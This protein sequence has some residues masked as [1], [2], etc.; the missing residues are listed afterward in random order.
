MQVTGP[1]TRMMEDATDA[2][3]QR[4]TTT[5]LTAHWLSIP[6]DS[7]TSVDSGIASVWEVRGLPPFCCVFAAVIDTT[8]KFGAT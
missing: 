7:V 3:L 5:P 1:M 6:T 2:T 8:K 4:N